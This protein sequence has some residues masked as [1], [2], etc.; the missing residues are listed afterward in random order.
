MSVR[1]T[2]SG[3]G[4]FLSATTAG[5]G[6]FGAGG[7][8]T[9]RR[10]ALTAGLAGLASIGVMSVLPRAAVALTG[11]TNAAIELG[12]EDHALLREIE[13]Y[14]N[15]LTTLQ[16]RFIQINPDGTPVEGTISMRR[17]GEMRVE[18]DPPNP[19]L[20]VAN[21]LFLIVVDQQLQEAT[22]LP[23]N[24]TPAYFFLRENIAFNDG[25]T[26][27]GLEQAA[28]LI[29]VQVALDDD[30]GAGSVI[31]TLQ[32]RPLTLR[33]WTVIDGQDARTRVTLLDT[34]FGL[35]LADDLFT[36]IDKPRDRSR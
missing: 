14:L 10:Q 9:A 28:G 24:L 22:H 15:R 13:D 36:Y 32:E 7:V 12:P 34:R 29:R 8:S 25:V 4:K 19:H 33:Q 6:S 5:R 18:Y 1:P 30:P 27:L 23:L 20:M 3:N 11:Q 16:S 35:S 2:M 31:V 17:P 26:V 21:G